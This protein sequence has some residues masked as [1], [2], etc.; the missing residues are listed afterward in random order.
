VPVAVPVA[1]PVEAPA[2]A[3]AL[4]LTT[5]TQVRVRILVAHRDRGWVPCGYFHATGAIEVEVLGHGE[6]GP[7]MIL[8][9]SCPVDFV[10]SLLE[11]G[12]VR[13]VELYARH[14]RWP[15]PVADKKLPAELPRR[16]VERMRPVLP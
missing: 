15:T 5:V 6:P 1:P 2:P 9:I 16:Q 11:I 13:D 12:A 4:D 14:Q 8:I 10:Q 7:R 3:E